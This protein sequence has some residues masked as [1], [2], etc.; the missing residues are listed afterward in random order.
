MRHVCRIGKAIAIGI[1][2]VKI[3]HLQQL[4]PVLH[5]IAVGVDKAGC[6]VAGVVNKEGMAGAK[7]TCGVQIDGGRRCAR[8]HD[9]I[10]G[11]RFAICPNADDHL[12]KT[13]NRIRNEPT[14]GIGAQPWH[15]SDVKIAKRDSQKL[16]RIRFH[17]R[18]VAD[19]PVM[20]AGRG[21]AIQ[22]V[23]G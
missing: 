15:T 13:R 18:P 23:A 6:C 12:R 21:F 10:R 2:H 4:A 20:R 1:Q 22:Q 19:G 17:I 3:G 8:N 16:Q 7:G 9:I 14:I 11:V 5:A